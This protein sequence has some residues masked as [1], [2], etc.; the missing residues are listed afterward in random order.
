MRIQAPL[1]K[2]AM[3]GP[4]LAGGG[5]IPP[6]NLPSITLAMGPPHRTLLARATTK[7]ST[8]TQT[9]MIVMYP[10][11]QSWMTAQ[12]AVIILNVKA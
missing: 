3:E 6:T 8:V 12:T 11:C 7:M 2:T 9:K 4:F 10:T 1:L 5:H